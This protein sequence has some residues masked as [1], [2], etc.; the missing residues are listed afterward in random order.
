[1]NG[2]NRSVRTID[3][4]TGLKKIIKNDMKID[5]K[6][7]LK[8]KVWKKLW[9]ININIFVILKGKYIFKR[10]KKVKTEIKDKTI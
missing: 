3:L 2:K 7:D 1:M 9:K 8:M 10:I 4:N 6:M 5:M